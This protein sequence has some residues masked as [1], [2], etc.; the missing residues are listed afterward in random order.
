MYRKTIWHQMAINCSCQMQRT[1]IKCL[2]TIIILGTRWDNDGVL[3]RPSID[4][5]KSLL[6]AWL[7]VYGTMAEM[8]QLL[9]SHCVRFCSINKKLATMELSQSEPSAVY[10]RLLIGRWRG[11]DTAAAPRRLVVFSNSVRSPNRRRMIILRLVYDLHSQ[12]FACRS[13]R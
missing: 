7:H 5:A 2:C 12:Q 10:G 1:K 3:W 9:R 4:G 8:D 6:P 13:H 11:R